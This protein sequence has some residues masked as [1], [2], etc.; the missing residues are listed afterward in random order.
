MDIISTGSKNHGSNPHDQKEESSKI[1]DDST[2]HFNT[3]ERIT[4]TN[5]VAHWTSTSKKMIWSLKN[6]MQ[7]LINSIYLHKNDYCLIT[8]IKVNRSQSSWCKKI[9]WLICQSFLL[10]LWICGWRFY[11]RSGCLKNRSNI[12]HFKLKNLS[13]KVH[14]KFIF[15]R[16]RR[17]LLF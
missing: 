4:F 5:L 10:G 16:W 11:E 8:A 12:H 7:L 3:C 1:A 14:M 15:K 6:N 13:L 9:S 17:A 2:I